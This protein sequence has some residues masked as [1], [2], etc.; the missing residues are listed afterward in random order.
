MLLVPKHEGEYAA[1]GTVAARDRPRPA[2]GRRPPRLRSRACTAASPARPRPTRRAAC[3]SR[4]RSGRTA[5]RP[6]SAPASSRR[7]YRAVVEEI[8]ELRGDDGRIQSFVRS[9]TDARRARRHLGLLARPHLRAEGAVARGRRRHGAARARPL[10]PARAALDHADPPADPRG[11]QRRHGEAAARVP[12]P[13]ADGLD[14]QGAR[15]GRRVRRRGVP[16]EDRRGGDARRACA[17]RPTRSSRASSG[18]ARA[19]PSRR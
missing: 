13:Q 6:T 5:S 4:S 3:S 8:L 18:W 17:S 14:P 1:V 19:H 11:R 7:E 9:I 12:A 15:R 10:V 16:Q 2:A